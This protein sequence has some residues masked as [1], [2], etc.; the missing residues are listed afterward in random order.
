MGDADDDNQPHISTNYPFT[1]ERNFDIMGLN[2]DGGPGSGRYPKGSGGNQ[3][4]KDDYT[5]S[6]KGTVTSDSKIVMGIGDHAAVQAQDRNV[7][8]DNIKRTLRSPQSTKPGNTGNRTVYV[9]D[10]LH[11]ILDNDTNMVV[12]VIYK[13]KG[14]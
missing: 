9:R 3:Y 4:I 14:K 1:S 12:T 8:P 5:K 11:V 7:Y 2:K 10:G 6:V 13:G